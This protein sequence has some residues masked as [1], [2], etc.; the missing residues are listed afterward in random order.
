MIKLLDIWQDPNVE[1]DF[2]L[3]RMTTFINSE[4]KKI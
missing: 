4:A 3:T 2:L 1:D